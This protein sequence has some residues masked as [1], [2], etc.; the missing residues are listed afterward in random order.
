[1]LKYWIG[2]YFARSLPPLIPRNFEWKIYL[3]EDGKKW[4]HG[5]QLG[6]NGPF[7]HGDWRPGQQEEEDDDEDEW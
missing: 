6:S 4:F 3:N 2:K 7:S 5:L 1:V